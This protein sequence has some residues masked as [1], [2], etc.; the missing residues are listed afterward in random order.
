MLAA[1]VHEILTYVPFEKWAKSFCRSKATRMYEL[2]L[3]VNPSH[4]V[5]TGLL[6]Y[7]QTVFMQHFSKQKATGK[8]LSKTGV[9]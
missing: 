9:S 5:K 2:K 6:T 7:L 3:T 4:T 1:I 8:L